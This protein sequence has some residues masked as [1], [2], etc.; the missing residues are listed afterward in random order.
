MAAADTAELMRTLVDRGAPEEAVTLAEAALPGT[1]GAARAELLIAM[2]HALHVRGQYALALRAS[3]D[4]S[5][6]FGAQAREAELCDALVHCAGTLRAAGQHASALN[7]LEQAEQMARTLGDALRL[8]RVLRQLGVVSSVLGRHRHALASLESALPLLEHHAPAAEQLSARLS[9]LNVRTRAL[10]DLETAAD[11]RQGARELLPEW[12]AL[13]D[14]AQA[15]GQVRVALMSRGN[16]AIAAHE[17]GL[18]AL[19]IESLLDLLPRYREAGM[20]PNEGLTHTEIGRCLETLGD[21]DRARQ[22]YRVALGILREAG[23]HDDLLQALEGLSRC[24]EQ[25]G[26]SAAALAALKELRA[27]EAQR[28]HPSARRAVAERELR[29]ELAR[30]DGQ[31][32]RHNVPDPSTG[33]ATRGALTRWL[34]EQWPRVEQGRPLAL[35]LLDLAHFR[36]IN[37]PLGP[38]T[39]EAV[40]AVV[41]GLMQAHCRSGDL[42]VRYGD[43]TFLLALA[44]VEATTAQTVSQRMLAAVSGYDWRP[45]DDALAVTASVAQAHS[46]EAEHAD[47]LLTLADQRLHRARQAAAGQAAARQVAPGC[48]R[49][50]A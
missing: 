37:E 47:A 38:G 43:E 14:A 27:L 46:G 13:A 45:L 19:A 48:S 25:Q 4:A 30:L 11:K 26:D 21:T 17:A 10:A 50:A 23:A 9:L 7:V 8:G 22:H 6:I 16:H 1:A 29:I 20:R 44:G 15:A 28:E 36:R 33:L 40:L 34:A 49:D 41:A 42:A 18:V 35:V 5:E 12:Q 24:E 3:V 32:A 2:A 39:G 31:W